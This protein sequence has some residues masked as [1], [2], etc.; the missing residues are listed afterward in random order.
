MTYSHLRKLWKFSLL[1]YEDFGK[2]MGISG[3]TLRRWF[4]APNHDQLPK[5][6]SVAAEGAFFEL[7][8][9]ELVD[10]LSPEIHD[11][12]VDSH[13]QILQSAAALKHLGVSKVFDFQTELGKNDTLLGLSQIGVQEEKVTYVDKNKVLIFSYKKM[14]AEWSEKIS[15]LWN[16]IKSKKLTRVDKLVAYGALFYLLTPI[17]FIPD[18]IPFFG[19]LDDFAIISSSVL[20][21]SEKFSG[22]I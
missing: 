12:L 7:I 19:L 3:M 22:R 16:V 17:D 21:Y 14:S 6:Y 9:K 5:L 10:P 1:S 2:M 18:H 4:K 20:Y 8:S 13:S 11:L 15:L